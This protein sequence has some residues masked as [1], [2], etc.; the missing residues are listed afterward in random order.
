MLL[1]HFALQL[2]CIAFDAS[3]DS[4]P[5][6][7]DVC[8][9]PVSSFLQPPQSYA[10]VALAH[11]L[12]SH[13]SYLSAPFWCPLPFRAECCEHFAIRAHLLPNVLSHFHIS[14]S[15]VSSRNDSHTHCSHARLRSR[16]VSCRA[17]SSCLRHLWRWRPNSR[18]ITPTGLRY[19][20]QTVSF[21]RVN[22]S[23]AV[24][25]VRPHAHLY[26]WTHTASSR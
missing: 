21:G 8:R 14:I 13:N 3:T 1:T 22:T 5:G 25:R 20:M 7:A 10:S 23:D 12:P 16:S 18:A 24:V 19:S 4:Q 15:S 9:S 11:V 17:T 2:S 6:V 26:A